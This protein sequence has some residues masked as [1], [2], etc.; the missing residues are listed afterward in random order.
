[1]SSDKP[2]KP[3]DD[4]Q[5]KSCMADRDYRHPNGKYYCSNCPMFWEWSKPNGKKLGVS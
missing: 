5:C 4:T 1:M 2:A 3:I